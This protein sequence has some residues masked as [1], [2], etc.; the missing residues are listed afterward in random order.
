MSKTALFVFTILIA[1]GIFDFA[2]VYVFKGL[3][4]ISSLFVDMHDRAQFSMYII[5]IVIGHLL[6]PTVKYVEKLKD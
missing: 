1:A 3:P 5:C 4:S 2:A 6:F